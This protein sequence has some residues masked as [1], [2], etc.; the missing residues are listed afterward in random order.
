MGAPRNEQAICRVLIATKRINGGDSNRTR[1]SPVP[2][3]GMIPLHHAAREWR[4]L[5][6]NQRLSPYCGNMFASYT[7]PLAFLCGLLNRIREFHGDKGTKGNGRGRG[8][9]ESCEKGG[10]SKSLDGIVQLRWV[11]V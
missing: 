7:I 3:A 10:R 1:I 6:L 9:N 11:P 2:C 5:D 4:Y 8:E